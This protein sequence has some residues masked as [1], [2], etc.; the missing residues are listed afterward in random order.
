MIVLYPLIMLLANFSA[1]IASLLFIDLEFPRSYRVWPRRKDK[2]GVRVKV[3]LSV[4]T[5][6]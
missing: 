4:N 5:Q 3:C 2:V 6:S 1:D